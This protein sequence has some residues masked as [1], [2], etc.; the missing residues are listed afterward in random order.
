MSRRVNVRGVII[1][2]G[3]LF[4]V[5]HPRAEGERD[6][7]C[8]PG[9]GLDD[10]ESLED[11]VRRELLEETGIEAHVGRLLFVQ[12]F[13][14]QPD[15]H[16][17][18]YDEF[19]EFFFAIDNPDDFEHIDLARTTHGKTELTAYDFVDPTQVDFLPEFLKNID[20]SALPGLDTPMIV[21][22]LS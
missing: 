2:D 14:K 9:G 12:Q 3:K 7:W 19:L 21:S 22:E 17:R 18:P 13:R 10:G 5:R 20:L 8:T 16:D 4:A 1:R 11:G 6:F 15:N